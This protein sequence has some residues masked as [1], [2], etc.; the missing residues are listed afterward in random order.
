MSEKINMVCENCGC[1]EQEILKKKIHE[2]SAYYL[3]K[4]PNCGRVREIVDKVKLSQVKLITSRYDLSESKIINIPEDEE[5]KVGDVINVDGEE[6]EITKI[7]T[8][9][10]VKESIGKDIKVIWGKSLSIP[11]KI[12]ISI[13]DKNKTYGIYLYVPNDFEFEIGKVYRINDGFFRL[14]K[15]KT[16]K[17]TAKKAKAKDIKRLY[18]DV[19]RPLRNHIDLTKFYREEE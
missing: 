4:C 6:I 15:I 2:K 10:S 17:T 14:K 19:V 11:K 9:R 16:D 3:I 7:E 12:G 13:N 18:G 1:E 5:Y 8:P